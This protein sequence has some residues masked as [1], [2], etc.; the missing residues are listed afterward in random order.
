M[1]CSKTN[2][3]EKFDCAELKKIDST[4][5]FNKK[6]KINNSFEEE[7]EIKKIDFK[8]KTPNQKIIFAD[9]LQ[10]DELFMEYEIIGKNSKKNWTLIKGVDYNQNYYYLINKNKIDTLIGIPHIFENK[11]LSIEEPY[12]DYSEL[13]EI[14]D[15]NNNNEIKLAKHFSIKFCKESNIEDAYLFETFLYLKCSNNKKSN[16]Y[17]LKF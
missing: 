12:T 4:E 9:H 11:I 1:F 3:K 8:I 10:E 16:F 14:W 5:Y 17:K 2:Q 15:I 7:S 6:P 13:I